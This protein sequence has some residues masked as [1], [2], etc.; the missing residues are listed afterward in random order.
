[1]GLGSLRRSLR[2][3]LLRAAGRLLRLLSRQP[4][5]ELRRVLLIKPDH[6]G[7]VLLLT[8]ALR[9]LRRQRPDLHVT[10]LIGPWSRVAVAHSRDFDALHTCEFPGFTRA[11]RPGLLQPYRL[12]LNTA[13]LLR[14]GRYDAALI[15]RDDHWWG[16]LLAALAGIPQRIG[17]AVA[18][19][20]PLLTTALPHSFEDH[21]AAQNLKLVEALTGEIAPNRPLSVAPIGEQDRD[22]A[23]RWLQEQGI[24][25]QT[26]LVAI[27]PG[28]GGAAKLWIAGRWVQIADALHERGLT[29]VLTGGPDEGAL[30]AAIAGSMQRLPLT[31]VGTTTL[32]QL[33]ALYERCALVLGVDSGPLHLAVSTGV[34]TLA[35][36][37]PGNWQRFGPWGDPQRHVV[38]RSD[39]WCS[40]CG[41]LAACPRGTAPS[42][43][44]ARIAVAQVLPAIDALL[45]RS[46]AAQAR[47]T[48]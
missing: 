26:R 40:P 35:L 9:L 42:E 19:T 29:L 12:L 27:H 41:V 34:P 28:A 36:F 39:L 4:P 47:P 16:A 30:V 2:L 46:A 31:L 48:R 33:A 8:P 43:C 10:L 18:E 15:A 25:P 14:A 32:G 45:D 1:L 6:L 38:I 20:A 44:M 3:L 13:L 7:D 11:A 5:R 23:A 37:G 22:W 21:V 24:S 17:F